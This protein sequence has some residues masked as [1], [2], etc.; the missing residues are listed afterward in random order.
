MPFQLHVGL[1]DV[2]NLTVDFVGRCFK[3]C[4]WVID[5]QGIE[6]GKDFKDFR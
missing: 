3:C 5:T 1:V 2:G 4:C 6:K